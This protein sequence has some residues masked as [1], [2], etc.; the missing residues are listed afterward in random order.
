MGLTFISDCILIESYQK[1]IKNNLDE[2][3]IRILEEELIRRG[4]VTMTKNYEKN[5]DSRL[6]IIRPK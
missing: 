4:F 6:F 1:A 2:D 3:F 5:S